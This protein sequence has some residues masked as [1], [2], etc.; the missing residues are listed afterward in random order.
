MNGDEHQY[1]WVRDLVALS[2]LTPAAIL[3]TL[4]DGYARDEIYVRGAASAGHAHCAPAG[5]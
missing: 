4:A 2:E 3:G 5:G 1:K